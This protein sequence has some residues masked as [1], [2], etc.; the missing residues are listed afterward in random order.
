VRKIGNIVRYTVEEID[1]MIAR[2]ED[3]TDWARVR[4][5]TEEELAADM[6][7]DPAWDGVPED[8]FEHAYKASGWPGMREQDKCEVTV[9]LDADVIDHF[10]GQGGDWESRINAALRVFVD[11]EIETTAPKHEPGE[12]G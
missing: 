5:K 4:A 9:R 12:R 6:A 10:K 1:A 8:W 7:S 11:R 2:G 3:Q